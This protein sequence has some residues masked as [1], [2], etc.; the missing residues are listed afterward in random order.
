MYSRHSFYFLSRVNTRLRQT[1]KS[2]DNKRIRNTFIVKINNKHRTKSRKYN[3]HFF[4]LT[5]SKINLRFITRLSSPVFVINIRI[6]TV[7][8]REIHF[9]YLLVSLN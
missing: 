5:K 4:L 8:E 9:N 2:I 6:K 7:W 3:K 1:N